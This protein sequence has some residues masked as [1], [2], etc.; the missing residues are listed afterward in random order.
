MLL[1]GQVPTPLSSLLLEAFSR[2]GKRA[3][4]FTQ[5]CTNS[6]LGCLADIFV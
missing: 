2:L 3:L 1:L 5:G 6:G 4:A